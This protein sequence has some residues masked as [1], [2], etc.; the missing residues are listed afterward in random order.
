MNLCL[1]TLSLSLSLFLAQTEANRKY[2]RGQHISV[3]SHY[4]PFLDKGNKAN[5]RKWDL[6]QQEDNED[7]RAGQGQV[8]V[9]EDM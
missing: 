2:H 8:Q 1:Y 4:V 6:N 9:P 5:V 7:K 3:Q